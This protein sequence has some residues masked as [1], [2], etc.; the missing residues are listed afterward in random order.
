MTGREYELHIN[1][2][3]SIKPFMQSYFR[4]VDYE[5]LGELDA[6]EVAETIDIAVD[7]LSK[8]IPKMPKI[9]HRGTIP[10]SA[11]CPRCGAFLGYDFR[12]VLYCDMCGQ[13]L[14]WDYY[15]ENE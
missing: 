9:E 6:T 13:A 2:L 11:S 3:K 7:A 14:N 1:G 10:Y 12:N 5:G 4:S 15:K 8:Q